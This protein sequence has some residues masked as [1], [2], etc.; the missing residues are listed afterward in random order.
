MIDAI[1]IFEDVGKDSI[2]KWESG[3]WSIDMC[4]RLSRRAELKIL[5][6]LSGDIS[7]QLPPEPWL[8]QKNKDWLAPFI[9]SLPVSITNGR[10]SKPDD[11]Y[12]YEDSELIGS[13]IEQDCEDDPVDQCDTNITLLDGDKYNQRCNTYIKDKKPSHK[14]PI[15]KME[16]NDILVTPK[17]L[18]SARLKYIRYPKFAAVGKTMDTTYNEEVPDPNNTVH[19]EWGEW[20]RELLIYWITDMFSNHIREQALKQFNQA[21]GKTARG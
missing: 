4:N 2:N 9:T 6:W 16:G 20:A 7:A 14:K 5:D 3:Y 17:D 8:T 1:S 21:S 12:K 10:F 13:K 15:A 19:Y 11:Y 18:G